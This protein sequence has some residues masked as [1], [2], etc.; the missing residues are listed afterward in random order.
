MVS[1]GH[2]E[3]YSQQPPI[4][5]GKAIHSNSHPINSNTTVNNCHNLTTTKATAKVMANNGT[6][7]T[8]TKVGKRTSSRLPVQQINDNDFHYYT[9]KED[10]ATWDYSYNQEWYAEA[11]Y[12]K[13]PRQE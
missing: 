3:G 12:P 10:P 9:Y 2:N 4:N 8:T 5:K 6:L 13:Q 1:K 11:D 7:D